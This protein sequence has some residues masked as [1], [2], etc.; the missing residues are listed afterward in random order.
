MYVYAFFYERDWDR[1]YCTLVDVEKAIES[2]DCQDGVASRVRF[3]VASMQ[4]WR[5]VP[6]GMIF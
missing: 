5:E 1:G 6:G 2:E 4:G 3:G